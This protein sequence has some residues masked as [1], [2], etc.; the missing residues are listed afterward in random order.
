MVFGI[1][2]LDFH[3]GKD[4]DFKVNYIYIYIY[5]K[6]DSSVSNY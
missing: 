6:N 3:H 1:K 2:V 4:R 5:I